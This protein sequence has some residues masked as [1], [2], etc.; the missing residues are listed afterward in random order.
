MDANDNSL[1]LSLD[2]LQQHVVKYGFDVFPPLD[3]RN[4]RARAFDLF[5]GLQENCP[6]LF[7]EVNFRPDTGELTVMTSYQFGQS[8]AKTATLTL[9]PRG[10]VFAIPLRLPDPLGEI[11]HKHD[12]DDVVMSALGKM[13]KS[14]PGLSV[15]RIG[16]IREVVFNT[17][18]S[19][20]IPF[21]A[22]RFGCFRNTNPKG[23]N[24]TLTFQDDNCNVRVK[25]D[26]IEIRRQAQVKGSGHVL[27]DELSYGLQVMLDVNN[28][29]MR[30]QE[31]HEIE[32][33]LVRAK[34]LWPKEL[35]EFLN[36][37]GEA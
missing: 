26:T 33:T 13:R 9:T 2:D 36:A 7:Q 32:N 4:E 34:G 31:A 3:V 35:L 10:P 5:A 19:D 12:L 28:I 17:G 27:T 29:E 15:L 14:F 16:L 21:L 23:G 25:I 22:R 18:K 11:S 37:K 24:V 1:L 20:S 6:E 30:P 8:S